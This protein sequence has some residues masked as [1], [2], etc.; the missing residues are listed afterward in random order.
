MKNLLGNWQGKNYKELVEKL[1]KSWQNIISN[2]SIKVR[3][4]TANWINFQIIAAMSDVQGERFHQD[5]KT[6]EEH[7]QEW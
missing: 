3:F 1:L 7:Y 6:M 4:Y 2:M 5:I